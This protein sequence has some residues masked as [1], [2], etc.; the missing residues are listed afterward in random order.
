MAIS[1]ISWLGE[2]TTELILSVHI[3]WAL[4]FFVKYQGFTRSRHIGVFRVVYGGILLC[5]SSTSATFASAAR[6][7]GVREF[8]I[9]SSMAWCSEGVFTFMIRRQVILFVFCLLSPGYYLHISWYNVWDGGNS[10]TQ[11]REYFA[12]TISGICLAIRLQDY[13]GQTD[14]ARE[15]EEKIMLL[16]SRLAAIL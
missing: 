8:P 5:P 12:Y 6:Q 2:P 15:A 10:H 4:G 9:A 3:P 7:F 16:G 1:C 11:H 13:D 14:R